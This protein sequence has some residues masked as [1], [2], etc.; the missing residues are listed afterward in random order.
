MEDSNVE[1]LKSISVKGN[2]KRI[3][4]G[5]F[6][7]KK[8]NNHFFIVSTITLV[9]RL[10]RKKISTNNI[11]SVETMVVLNELVTKFFED[12]EISNKILNI[13]LSKVT[14]FKGRSNF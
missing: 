8:E 12:S 9:D 14:K 1:C 10:K 2:N 7:N 13:E 11:Y 3:S 4:V 6:L 5:L